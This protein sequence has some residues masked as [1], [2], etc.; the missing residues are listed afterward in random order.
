[1]PLGQ[2]QVSIQAAQIP[3]DGCGEAAATSLLPLSTL[4]VVAHSG[5]YPVTWTLLQIGHTTEAPKLKAGTLG[6]RSRSSE[7]D[8]RNLGAARW[9]GR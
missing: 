9:G 5:P 6:P 7:T 1:M 2:Q 3:L 4:G 8:A